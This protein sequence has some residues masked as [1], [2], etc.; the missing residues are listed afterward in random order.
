[1][2]NTFT[3][4]ATLLTI[5]TLSPLAAS[6]QDTKDP[7]YYQIKDE[8]VSFT[9]ASSGKAVTP[10]QMPELALMAGMNKNP[11][12]AGALVNAGA[13]AWGVISGGAPSGGSGSAFAS[14]IP[15][16]SFNWG[17][18]TGWKG[19]KEI[20]YSYKV[21]NLYNIDV[22]NVKYK[23][24]FFYGGTEDGGA[25]SMTANAFAQTSSGRKPAKEPAKDETKGVY[26]TNFTVQPVEINIMWGW[27]FDLSVKMSDPMNIGTKQHPVA[28]LQS[29][30]NWILS[31]PL[32]TKGG[33]WTYGVDGNGVFKDLTQQIKGVNDGLPV[34][35][36]MKD[37]PSVNWQ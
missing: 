14:A 1:M 28:Y 3:T 27:K 9:E 10:E 7:S 16:F 13:T 17:N 29:D 11:L 37:V 34:P 19:P 8:S 31:T 21:T 36:E 35:Q 2:K 12:A 4:A 5:L 24:S 30:L 26:I 18:I 23:V 22:I 20:I 6:A 32:S 15:G 25:A 33:T